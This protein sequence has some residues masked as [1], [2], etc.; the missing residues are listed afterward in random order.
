MATQKHTDVDSPF[1]LKPVEWHVYVCGE[2]VGSVEAVTWPK[3]HLA[4]LSDFDVD[5]PIDLSVRPA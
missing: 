3:A 4:A 5:D 1:P 2:Y